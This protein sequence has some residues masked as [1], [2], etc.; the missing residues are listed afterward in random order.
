MKGGT[1][2]FG[3]I[4]SL[5]LLRD[6]FLR[7]PQPRLIFMQRQAGQ[8]GSQGLL[9]CSRLLFG[10]ICCCHRPKAALPRS[11]SIASGCLSAMVS[12]L[13]SCHSEKHK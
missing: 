3:F 9:S 13:C 11:P 1:S 7:S 10:Y 5:A 12:G 2:R 6:T 8:Y 4:S